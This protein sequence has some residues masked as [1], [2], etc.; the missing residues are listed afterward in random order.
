MKRNSVKAVIALGRQGLKAAAGVDRDIPVVV[1]G[2]LSVPEAESRNLT[3]VT[4]TPD[5]ALLF[6]HLK[7]LLPHIKRV[8]VVYDPQRE[9]LM[10]KRES[11]RV[12]WYATGGDFASD[13]TGRTEE[14][15]ETFTD[16]IWTAPATPGQVSLWLVLRD[17]RGGVDFKALQLTVQ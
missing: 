17:S 16:N 4:L 8:I 12:S 6:L 13:S 10:E 9:A 5:P 3:G 1:G 11:L 7:A 15:T 14:E 2:V